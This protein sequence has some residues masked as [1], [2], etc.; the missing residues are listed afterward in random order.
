MANARL[1]LV[2]TLASRLGVG[3]IVEQTLRMAA[4]SGGAR[5]GRKLLT[6]VH[7][8]AAGAS[9]IDHADVLRTGETA[10]Y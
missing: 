5:P 2:A 1:L 9:D 3:R 7:G 6:L 8:I 4:S 10:G